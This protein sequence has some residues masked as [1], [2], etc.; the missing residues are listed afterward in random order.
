[1]VGFKRGV[2]MKKSILL[3]AMVLVLFSASSSM[4]S[5]ETDSPEKI[6][7]IVH[8]GT[9]MSAAISPDGKQI[10]LDLQ[11][12]IWIVPSNGGKAKRITDLFNDARQPVWSP[13]GKKLVYFA[14]RDGGYDIW[15][16]SPDGSNQKKLTWGAF[17][18]RE[19]SWSPDGTK[20]A[21][22]SDRGTPGKSSYNIWTLDIATGAF[23]QITDDSFENRMPT[24]S[25]DGRKIAYSS[26]RNGTSGIWE[27]D[28]ITG[29]EANIKTSPGVADAP[30]YSPKGDLAYVVQNDGRSWLE[31]NGNPVSGNQNVF[32]F[33]VSWTPSNEMYYV[34]D[35]KIHHASEG[36][37]TNVVEFEADLVAEKPKYQHS[38]RDF[39]SREPR[40]ALGI[41][42]PT[43]S[44]DGK[45]VAFIALGDLYVMPIG[46]KPVNLTNDRYMDI[47][48]SWSPDG[49]KLVYSSD[50]GGN[51]QQ[52][53]VRDIETGVDR[54]LTNMDTQP[55]EAVW[56][57]DGNK[58]AFIDAD[59]MWG[60]AGL[61]VVDVNTGDIT[62]LKP[63]LGQPGRPSWSA[64]SKWI[65][66][67]LSM[68]FSKSFREGTNQVFVIKADG[69]GESHWYSPVPNL[70]I[71]TRGGA[72]P[73]W[74]PDGTKMAAIYE[75]ELR[76]WPVSPKGKP[77][78]PPRSVTNEM[79]HSPSW[80]NDSRTI[81]FQSN[82]ELKTVDIE[83]GKISKIP[84]E[85]NYRMK[86]PEGRTVIHV[87]H[88]FDGKTDHLLGAKDIIVDGNII[89]SVTPHD[90]ANHHGVK[91]IVDATGLTAMPG[92]I[93]Y[94]A[95]PMRDFG[96]S[97]H[98]AWLAWGVTTVRNPG[99]QP[100]HGVEDREASE[101]GVRIGPRIYAT[102]HLIEWQRV[103]YKMGTAIS[104][105][106]HLEKELARAKALKYDL[107]KSYVRLPD[108]QQKRLVEFAHTQMGVPVTTHEIYPA[109]FVGVDNTEHMGATSRRG[110]S[111]KQASLGRV[112]EDVIDLFGKT[113]RPLTPTNFGAL[114]G[115][116]NKH[117]DMRYDPRIKM[118]P[119]W[120]QDGVYNATSVPDRLKW[121]MAG[122]SKA[123]K[124]IFDAGGEIVAGTD[125]PVAI[126]LHAE[127]SSYVDAGLT[128]FQAL[129]SA[130][131][132][133]A[134]LLQ[135]NAGSLEKGK[136]ADIV[137]VDGNP[138]E[139]I[140]AAAN[141]KMVMSNGRIYD[142]DWLVNPKN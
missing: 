132:V 57:P 52:L 64:D 104:G 112:Y 36:K 10:A 79:A 101:A 120:A 71:D 92:L 5:A 31:I 1:M 137:I 53:W 76:V 29:K 28:L 129:Q 43:I 68:P 124:D 88:V 72:G 118:Y 37:G 107:L 100:Y 128:P 22:S 40:R 82:D 23:N 91:N 44:P 18:D 46:E 78:G 56:S 47:D 115:Y 95:H 12:S 131:V 109:A 116:L 123:I 69:S 33:R 130:T 39:F 2:A 119:K 24:W 62:R 17:D 21:F 66:I 127:I 60:V 74:S 89:T 138:L 19:P 94:H 11:G 134:K 86:I 135:L 49:K 38:V 83:T 50:K 122:T 67:P 126:N 97:M 113:K 7:V 6:D 59:G 13:D 51:L 73:V 20:I 77:L 30:S 136:L 61:C 9:S 54:Q 102:G 48:P 111:P 81:L 133:P 84:L 96:E 15:T 87:S 45:N 70:S 98:R 99:D 141:V 139:D 35:G 121:T 55:L 16:I 26:N 114:V 4:L 105:P 117:P 63:S 32:P 93:E 34:A 125:T 75:G 3:S 41:V 140:G 80:A 142:E 14:F 106:A 103:Y 8:E 110:Y 65:S 25:P 85:L 58:I 27:M 90:D 42:R 108:L